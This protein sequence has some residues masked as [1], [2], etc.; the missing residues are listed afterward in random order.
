MLAKQRR[1]DE[2]NVAEDGDVEVVLLAELFLR[3]ADADERREAGAEQAERE[4]GRVLVGVEPDHED[5]ERRREHGAGERAGAEGEPVAAGVDGRGEAGDAGD[6]HDPFGAEV[7]DAGALVDEQAEGGEGEHGARVERRRDEECELVH[8]VPSRAGS[9][10][11]A[12]TGA[13]GASTIVGAPGV[14]GGATRAGFQRK[15]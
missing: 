9:V 12:T 11:D 4:A 14:A 5:A 15:R 6:Q 13:S 7:D 2:R 10:V 3:V 8:H 1:A